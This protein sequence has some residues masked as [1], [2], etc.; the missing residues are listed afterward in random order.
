[1]T[2]RY[3]AEKAVEHF[4][5]SIALDRCTRMHCYLMTDDTRYLRVAADRLLTEAEKLGCPLAGVM[6]A[7]PLTADVAAVREIVC[8]RSA[9]AEHLLATAS[10]F[11]WSFF[12]TCADDPADAKLMAMH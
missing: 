2:R 5:I 12:T 4:L 11:Y 1:M 6:L 7:T 10:D 9:E 3:T 8:K